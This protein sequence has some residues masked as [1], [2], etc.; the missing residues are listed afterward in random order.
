MK[1]RRLASLAL[2]AAAALFGTTGCTFIT[3]Q[4]T[5]IPYNAADGVGFEIGNAIQV[6]DALIVADEEG[7]LGNLIGAI[8]NSTDS[9]QTIEIEYGPV[10]DSTTE[11]VRVGAGEILTLG[12]AGEAP[13]LLVDIDTKP[14]AMMP[15]S[16]A[17]DGQQTLA[18]LPVL[19]GTL[20]QYADLVPSAQR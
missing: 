6:R 1:T 2:V 4:A 18:L 19:D 7:R 3:H 15:V 9:A 5:T 20:P 11:R 16:F 10:G 8:I 12:H 13:L 14:G 17:A